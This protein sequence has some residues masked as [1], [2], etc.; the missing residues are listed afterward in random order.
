MKFV[1]PHET[2]F[3]CIDLMEVIL[4][5][6]STHMGINMPHKAYS[7]YIA[8]HYSPA[9]SRTDSTGCKFRLRCYRSSSPE[10]LVKWLFSRLHD[11]SVIAISSHDRC[12]RSNG[13][14]VLFSSRKQHIRESRFGHGN[15]GIALSGSYKSAS[16]VGH[17]A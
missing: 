3:Q 9:T 15:R 13:S 10:V 5:C 14:Q 8:V 2:I 11:E 6:S 1:S 12:T 16:R 7:C 17:T 4:I